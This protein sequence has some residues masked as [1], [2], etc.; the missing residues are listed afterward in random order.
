LGDI[1]SFN[2]CHNPDCHTLETVSRV[3]GSGTNKVLRTRKITINSNGYPS[4]IWE[5]FCNQNCL[6]QFLNKFAKQITDTYSVKQPKE[7]PITVKKE[8]VNGWR[9]ERIETRIIKG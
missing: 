6:F 1:V 8:K 2:W 3:R 5:Y 7:T 4:G 9:G